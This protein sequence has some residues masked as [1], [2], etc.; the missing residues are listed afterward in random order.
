MF[1]SK[2][3]LRGLTAAWTLLVAVGAFAADSL[4]DHVPSGA[5]LTAELTDAAVLIERVRGSDVL[6]T[7][8]DS[9]P[10]RKWA[11]SGDGRKFRGGRAVLEGQLGM[12]LWEAATRLIG[13]RVAVALYP[14]SNGKQPDG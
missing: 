6:R 4:T 11:A 1:L 8:V 9:E 12:N 3:G 2:P 7:V 13:N 14:P 10:Y 5:I